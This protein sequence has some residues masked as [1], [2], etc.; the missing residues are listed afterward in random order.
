MLTQARDVDTRAWAAAI[1]AKVYGHDFVPTLERLFN[2]GDDQMQ[3]VAL[4]LLG[5][6]SP[7]ALEAHLPTLRRKLLRLKDGDDVLQ[8]MCVIA[9]LR[10]V[11]ALPAV[12]SLSSRPE[13]YLRKMADVLA[14]YLEHGEDVVLRRIT[15]HDHEHIVWLC[16]LAWHIGTAEALQAIRS[17]AGSAPDE[18]CPK[19]CA[20]FARSLES[21][22]GRRQPPY[23]DSSAPE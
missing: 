11:G 17:C 16:R 4:M 3:S 9:S 13:P 5:E 19:T 23:W 18:E 14:D 6:V 20:R 7:A 2:D 21:I 1:G 15:E 10:D 22:R 12:R 8:V